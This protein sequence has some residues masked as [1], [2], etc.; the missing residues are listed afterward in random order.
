MCKPDERKHLGKCKAM[1]CMT[2]LLC[3]TMSGSFSQEWT[4]INDSKAYKQCHKPGRGSFIGGLIDVS[5]Q[6]PQ[7]IK[8]CLASC[9]TPA[10]LRL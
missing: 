8:Q 3:P 6:I 4:N 9:N 5:E 1:Q 2:R 10:R 7:R